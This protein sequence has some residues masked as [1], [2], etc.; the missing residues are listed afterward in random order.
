MARPRN[1]KHSAD[2]D[3]EIRRLEEEKRRL[4]VAEDQRRGAFIREALSGKSGDQLRELL[5]P[6]VASR[7]AFLFGLEPPK[8]TRGTAIPRGSQ[9]TSTT[10]D[11]ASRPA[12]AG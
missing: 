1:G 11:R 2:I 7:E 12:I 3:A 9:D 10:V 4:I 8:Q 6:L 5:R